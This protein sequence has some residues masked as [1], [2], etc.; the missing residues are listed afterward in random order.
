MLAPQLPKPWLIHEITYSEY[1]DERDEYGNDVFEL[2]ITIGR[3]RFDESSSFSRSVQEDK[4]SL[5]GIIF[6]DGVNS[7]NVP[8]SFLEQS[9]VTF[10]G[11]EMTIVKVIDCYHPGANKIHHYEL[12]VV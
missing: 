10:N 12:E 4:I 9:K 11:R 8:S 6:V 3:V 1:S 2:P 7:E 5:T